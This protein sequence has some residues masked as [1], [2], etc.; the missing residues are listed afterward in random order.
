MK[1]IALLQNDVYHA[2]DSGVF[3]S[4]L[5]GEEKSL[6][7]QTYKYQQLQGI[8]LNRPARGHRIFDQLS[9]IYNWVQSINRHRILCKSGV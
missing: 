7:K 1:D 5:I 8:V 9:F 2:F 4:S 3:Q 6:N